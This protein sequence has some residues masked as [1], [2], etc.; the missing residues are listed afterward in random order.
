MSFSQAEKYLG[1]STLRVQKTVGPDVFPSFKQSLAQNLC[2][3]EGDGHPL[4]NQ[5]QKLLSR[6][7]RYPGFFVCGSPSL[8]MFFGA[9]QVF[10]QN[11]T[12]IDSQDL[13]PIIG[14]NSGN[15]D[16]STIEN[17]E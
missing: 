9:Q 8:E 4:L 16:A 13:L 14:V 6:D 1:Q 5:D 7:D 11:A 3:I 17:K 12:R 10:S 15:P 2:I